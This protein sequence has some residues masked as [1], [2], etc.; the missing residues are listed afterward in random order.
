MM[1]LSEQEREGERETRVGI[2]KV[3]GKPS[4]QWEREAGSQ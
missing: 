3:P 2:G 4:G 1:G